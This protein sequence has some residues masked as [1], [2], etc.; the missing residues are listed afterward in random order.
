MLDSQQ[1]GNPLY[2]FLE[3]FGWELDRTRTLIETLPLSIDPELAVTPALSEIAKQ[4]GLETNIEIVGTTK[5]RNLLNNIGYIRRRKGTIESISYYL[6]ALTGC[7]IT[8]EPTGSGASASHK[9]NVHSERVNF[10]ADPTFYQAALAPTTGTGSTYR[11]SLTKSAT[12]GVYSYG[13]TTTTGASV[14]TN[15]VGSDC[16]MTVTNVGTG[17]IDVLIY[18]R[19]A[20]PYYPASDVYAG[21]TSSK[22]TGASFTNFHLATEAKMTEW[23]S[24]VAS[25]SVPS[26]LFYDTWNDTKQQLPLDAFHPDEERYK[27]PYNSTSTTTVNTIPVLQFSLAAGSSVVLTKLLVEPFAI[28][29]YFDGNTREGALLPAVSGLGTGTSDYRWDPEGTEHESFS[30]YMLDYQ[31]VHE[32]VS[33]II[34]NYIAP[35]TVKDQISIFW[36]YYYGKT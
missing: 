12:W 18:Q 3:L 28:S 36:N 33:D 35:I 23:E 9:F 13:A 25:G 14:T 10:A 11:T 7:V 32:V 24:N 27:I 8:Y 22:T 2:N 31:K 4:M 5:V 20:F 17:T 19:T 6:S 1:E 29:S 34:L 15:G 30:Y 26:P 16:V 21:F